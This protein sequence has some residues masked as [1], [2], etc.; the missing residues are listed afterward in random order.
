MNTGELT[1]ITMPRATA[2]VFRV[3]AGVDSSFSI[4]ELARVAGIS[5]PRA[6]EIV[7]HASER[8][9]ILVELAGRSRMCRLN[10]D[11][12]VADAVI[13]LVTIRERALRAIEHEI[14]SWRIAPL[15][16][17]LFGSFARGDGNLHSDLDL[18]LIRP[19]SEPEKEW[20]DQK[21]TS[22]VRLRDKIGNHVSWFDISITELK[23]AMRA[24][25]PIIAEWKKEGISLSGVQLSDVVHQLKG[26]AKR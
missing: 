1:D 26:K 13:E 7:N 16:A 11:H 10:R 8:G 14:A 20:E 19:M 22:G 5:A 25:E 4:R 24:S 9:L 15:H 12:L 23:R 6:V 17:S 18:L 3:L 2:A 21:Y